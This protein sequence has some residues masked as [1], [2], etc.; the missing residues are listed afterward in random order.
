MERNLL[1]DVL[2]LG[3]VSGGDTMKI[4]RRAFLTSAAI[5]LSSCMYS[6]GPQQVQEPTTIRVD[7][8]SYTDMTIYVVRGGQRVRLGMAG[9]LKATT[10]TIP[11]TLVFGSTP[12]RFIAD[13][14]GAG[15]GPVSDEITVKAGDEVGLIIPP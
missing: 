13:P 6:R 10:L 8:Q 9:G 4:S 7:N 14:I 12:M 5:M 2:S 1:T 15:R 3:F 11:S